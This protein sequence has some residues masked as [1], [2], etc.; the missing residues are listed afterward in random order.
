MNLQGA[1]LEKRAQA[2]VCGVK[3]CHAPV[4]DG[5]KPA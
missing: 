2:L 3:L 1:L 5:T 4:K